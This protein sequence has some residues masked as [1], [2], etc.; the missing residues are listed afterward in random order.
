MRLLEQTSANSKSKMVAL[1]G[2]MRKSLHIIYGVLKSGRQFNA[3][4]HIFYY[5]YSHWDFSKAGQLADKSRPSPASMSHRTSL[6]V[7]V[8]VES[9]N[10][11]T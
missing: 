2:A 9:P 8:F 7:L 10:W 6:A 5:L 3:K 1:G 11:R 4:L